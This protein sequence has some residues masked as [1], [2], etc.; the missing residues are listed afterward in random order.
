MMLNPDT[1]QYTSAGE[2]ID[3]H[4][5]VIFCNDQDAR[6]YAMD[7]IESHLCTRF[8]LGRFVMDGQ[9]ERMDISVV[10]TFGFKNDK[11]NTAQL[12]FFK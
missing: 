5:G 11:R 8:V 4:D 9:K 2:R 1:T 7:A 6:E 10:E 3:T 12:S